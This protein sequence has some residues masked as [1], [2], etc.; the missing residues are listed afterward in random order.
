MYINNIAPLQV[1]TSPLG[2]KIELTLNRALI[3]LQGESG[4][5]KSSQLETLL[6]RACESAGSLIQ[7]AVIDGKR[8]S[9]IHMQPRVF[10]YTE[11]DDWLRVL[12]AFVN[13]MNRRFIQ[14]TEECIQDY[15]ISATSPFLLLV[16]DEANTVF[17]PTTWDKKVQ[18]DEAMHLLE[19][20]TSMC[21]QAAMGVVVSGQSLLS[22]CISTNVRS[23]LST[24]F[25]LRTSGSEQAK[26]INNGDFEACDPLL[27]DVGMPGDEFVRTDCTNSHWIRCRADS[28]SRSDQITIINSLKRDKCLPPCL[29]FNNPDYV[30]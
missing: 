22:D 18:R 14:M 19:Q 26:A 29:D 21:R 12:R 25:A 5:G 16:I 13:E 15:P 1:A 30:G 3:A 23:N 4:S 7:I 9:F 20:Y 11:P 28:I 24:R 17:A 8:L 10:V 6:L 27:L 2:Q